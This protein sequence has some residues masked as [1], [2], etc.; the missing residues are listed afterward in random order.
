MYTYNSFRRSVIYLLIPALLICFTSISYGQNAKKY[1]KDGFKNIKDKQYSEAITNFNTALRINPNLIE[2]YTGR[3]TA[4][5]ATGKY[6]EALQDYEKAITYD[7]MNADLN[8]SAGNVLYYL[9]EYAKALEKFEK[10]IQNDAKYE[11]AYAKSALINYDEKNWDL[12]IGNWKK[13]IGTYNSKNPYYYMYFGLTLD[14]IEDY[15]Y[16]EQKYLKATQLY[17]SYTKGDATKLDPAKENKH[18]IYHFYIALGRSQWKQEKLD[19]A[20]ANYIKAANTEKKEP[21]PHYLEGKIDF[22]L[23]NYKAAIDK[24][25]QAIMLDKNFK[26]AYY[27]RGCIRVKQ[28]E[29]SL[30]IA[31]FEKVLLIDKNTVLAYFQRGICYVEQGLKEKARKDLQFTQ[32]H[33]SKWAQKTYG[34][35][36]ANRLFELS[37][38]DGVPE[39][40]ITQNFKDGYISIP[41]DATTHDIV[42]KVIDVSKIKIIKV[43]GKACDFVPNSL[44]PIF[45]LKV[46]APFNKEY[47]LTVVDVYNNKSVINYPVRFHE[48]DIPAAT[49]FVPFASNSEGKIY[50]S[51]SQPAIFVQGEID[52]ASNIH[53]ITIGGK[54]ATF[55]NNR[56][57][58]T[59]ESTI[60]IAGKL[61]ITLEVIDEYGN[62]MVQSYDIERE[63]SINESHMGKTL[64]IFIENSKYDNFGSLVGPKKD[65]TLIKNALANYGITTTLHKR[66]LNK[67]ALVTFFTKDL[68]ELLKT[69]RY[70]SLIVWYAGHGKFMNDRGYWIPTDARR[71]K[72]LDYYSITDLQSQ[73]QWYQS[74]GLKHILVISDACESGPAFLTARRDATVMKPTCA[75]S[76]PNYPSS[77]QVLT[78]SGYESAADISLFTQKFAESLETNQNPCI[79]IDEIA[80]DV[81]NALK[82]SQNKEPKFGTIKGLEDEGGTFIFYKKD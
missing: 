28:G 9:G 13:A 47:V 1:S 54:Q 42:G 11:L 80:N 21:L 38:E 14:S 39:V 6:E 31:D 69:A 67:E 48:I 22:Y 18:N 51:G 26:L 3:G 55:N 57:N 61:S 78:S 29:Y 82:R 49:I 50:V 52:D 45:S 17:T 64:L 68:G 25:N 7:V 12:A 37:R 81:I 60:S 79:S 15:I 75:Y 27:Q 20:R 33:L 41:Y 16:A 23:T 40:E 77:V 30:A 34:E 10:A 74:R 63:A 53:S 5:E 56:K 70:K 65:A 62:K 58:P 72:E 2:A 73:L 66:N 76:Q 59:F 4:F 43:D 71:G 44:N 46:D 24:F 8:Y 19:L 36:L 32:D 35:K